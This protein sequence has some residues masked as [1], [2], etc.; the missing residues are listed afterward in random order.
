[1]QQLLEEQ[2][3]R[4]C[5]QSVPFRVRLEVTGLLAIRADDDTTRTVL[6]LDKTLCRDAVASMQPGTTTSCKLSPPTVAHASSSAD[7]ETACDARC[8]SDSALD[9][10]HKSSAEPLGYSAS[11][12]GSSVDG[13]LLAPA[14][15]ASRS[16]QLLAAS[17]ICSASAAAGAGPAGGASCGAG[18]ALRQTGASDRVPEECSCALTGCAS[19]FATRRELSVHLDETHRQIVCAWCAHP[20]STRQNLK[21]HER[22]HTGQR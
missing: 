21:R 13:E 4:L 3:L 18:S 16:G 14:S 5:E 22:L 19:A 10:S 20:F 7:T 12:S 6:K 9:L 1:V 8:A 2:L 17:A 11:T 15:S